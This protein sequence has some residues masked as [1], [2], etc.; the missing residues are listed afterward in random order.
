MVER[1]CYLIGHH[2][3]YKDVDGA[4]YQLLLEADFL[5]NAYEDA[6]P[7]KPF[8][9]SARKS[10]APPAA[11]PCSMQS[12]ALTERHLLKWATNNRKGSLP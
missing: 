11:R 2:H 10:S 1:I 6:L 12:T 3:T 5:V 4:D 9:H 7:Q 8:S